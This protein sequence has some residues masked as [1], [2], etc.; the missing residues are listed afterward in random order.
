MS[1][2]QARINKQLLAEMET[3]KQTVEQI[4]KL[5]RMLKKT[6]DYLETANSIIVDEG[7]CDSDEEDTIDA[8]R[9]IDKARELLV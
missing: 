5:K 7:I 6:S 9:L 4:P 1:K 2:R 3:L 8:L